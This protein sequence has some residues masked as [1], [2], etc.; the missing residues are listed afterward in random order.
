MSFCEVFH[1]L[2]KSGQT[3]VNFTDI[4][5]HLYPKNFSRFDVCGQ[6]DKHDDANKSILRW[7]Y[8]DRDAKGQFTFM[9]RVDVVTVHNVQRS[10]HR[11]STE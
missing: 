5:F 8:W 3:L 7:F 6:T 4:D 11:S 2:T 10:L 9:L 1:I